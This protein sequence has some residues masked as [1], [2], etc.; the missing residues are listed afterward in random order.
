MP[1]DVFVSHSSVDKAVADATVA[2]LER[3]GLR[4]WVA[5]RDISPGADWGTSI[6]NAI[7]Q[8]RA[9]VIIFSAHSNSSE[10]VKRE[11]ERAIASKIPVI[12]LRIENILPSGAMEFFL[13]TP[14]WMDALTPP[15]EAHLERL[16][17]A[18]QNLL[19]GAERPLPP[20]PPKPPIKLLIGL[21]ALVL[22][23]MLAFI[24]L[25]S[26]LQSALATVDPKL[27]GAWRTRPA[28]P[29]ITGGVQHHLRIDSNE[30]WQMNTDYHAEGKLEDFNLGQWGFEE[31]NGRIVCKF[32]GQDRLVTSTVFL[33]K[34]AGQCISPDADGQG[35]Y[36]QQFHYRRL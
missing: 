12:P 31:R 36:L 30:S 23:A 5:P 13:S 34:R 18:L 26:Y 2:V 17:V 4:C 25:R 6:M 19:V 15:I 29:I 21:G 22:L 14:H 24:P 35:D 20:L 10:H 7:H 33:L 3:R 16:A 27:V 9:M 1:W 28:D 32:D 8:A 11:V